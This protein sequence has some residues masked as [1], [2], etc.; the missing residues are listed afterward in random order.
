MLMPALASLL[1]CLLPLS[2]P[3]Q[4]GTDDWR[5]F[6]GTDQ[7]ATSATAVARTWS[8]DSNL[9]WKTEL[10]GPGTSSPI[11]VGRAI[12]VTCWTGYALD[13]DEPGDLEKLRRH[14]VRIDADT[15]K[16]IWAR[17]IKPVETEDE[18]SGRMSTH[19]YASST[20]VSDGKHV[21]VFFG[22]SGVFCFDLDGKQVWHTSVGTSSSQWTTGSGSSLSLWRDLLLVNAA[23]ESHSLR[24][25]DKKTGK[26][27]WK[28]S[29]PGLDQAYATPLV[30]DGPKPV[31][32]FPLLGAIWGLDP[33]TGEP[34][35]TLDTKTNGALAPTLI[36]GRGVAYSFGGQTGKR[37]HAIRLGDGEDDSRLLWSS[38]LGSYVT[39]PLLFDKHLY[40]VSES[41]VAHCTNAETGELVYRKRLTG[42]FYSSP[43]RAGDA[44]Y[45]V[46]R[47]DGTYVVAAKPEFEQLAHNELGA[48]DSAFDA[49]PAISNGR[50]FL[51][52]R[53]YLYCIGS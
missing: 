22:K 10:P 13:K 14:L 33:R 16:Q 7:S 19:G 29:T 1:P 47:Q 41:G 48:D 45:F 31:L 4:D 32:C 44:I 15:G 12:F 24:A 51:R 37:S 2:I 27:V 53:R 43:V 36:A 18:F 3:A 25:L 8:A 9:R 35:W 38:S 20:P 5:A 50:L 23:D 17:S 46:S 34:R 26:E 28:R 21:Y 39:T 52:S 11:I 40:W 49:T 42:S 30:I 6:R